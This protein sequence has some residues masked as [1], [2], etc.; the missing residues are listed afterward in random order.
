MDDHASAASVRGRGKG[1]RGR[2]RGAFVES[3][4]SS[5]HEEVVGGPPPLQA[6]V[7]AMRDIARAIHNEIPPPLPHSL[8]RKTSPD[9]IK[10][11]F[12]HYMKDFERRNPP[13]FSGGSDVMIAKDWLQRINRIFTVIELKDDTIWIN[14]ATFQFTSEA[15]HWWDITIISNSIETM[16]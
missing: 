15:T 8:R 7:E 1:R 16:K 3:S 6:M 11:Q 4:S 10:A 9:P 2:G 5:G 13:I 12:R 14:P